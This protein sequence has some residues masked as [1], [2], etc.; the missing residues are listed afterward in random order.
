M[1]FVNSEEEQERIFKLDCYPYLPKKIQ[2]E[3][4][5]TREITGKVG[6]GTITIT[7]LSGSSEE[8]ENK[9]LFHE[10]KYFLQNSPKGN[11]FQSTNNGDAFHRIIK[12]YNE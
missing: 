1:C 9:R 8:N 10:G 3:P 2:L 12:L 7:I 4:K 6:K 11:I 5:Q